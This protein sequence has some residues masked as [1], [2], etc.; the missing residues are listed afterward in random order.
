MIKKLL[1]LFILLSQIAVAQSPQSFK[2]QSV[3]R[4]A[5]GVLAANRIISIRTSILAGSATGSSVYTETQTLSTNDYGVVSLNIGA[6]TVVSG[7]FSTINWGATNYF[8]KTELDINGGST[9]IFMGTSQILSVP[10]ALY[11]EKAGNAMADHDTSSTNELQTLSVAGH[12]LSISN[13]NTVLLPP[14]ADSSATNELQNLSVSGHSIAISSGN[15]VLLPKDTLTVNGYTLGVSNGNT[16]NLPAP[17]NL[18]VNGHTIGITSGNSVLI[19]R[20]TLAV[21]GYSLGITNGNTV[22]LPPPQNLSIVGDSLHITNGNTIYL[23]GA[24]D[25]DSDPTNELQNLTLHNDTLKISR[26][27]ST[28]VFP[29]DNDRDSTN[30]LQNLSINQGTIHISKG[31]SISLPDSSATNELQN[32]SINQGT[33]SISQGNSIHLPDSSATNELQNLIVTNDTLISI[34]QGN[35]AYINTSRSLKFPEGID[36]TPITLKDIAGSPIYY[37]VPNGK[38]LYLTNQWSN[39]TNY[40]YG[41]PVFPSGTILSLTNTQLLVG[42]LINQNSNVQI[43]STQVTATSTY[44]VP[45]GKYF[46][47]KSFVNTGNTADFRATLPSGA[48][49]VGAS[50][51]TAEVLIFPS[52]TIFSSPTSGYIIKISGYLK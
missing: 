26:T 38:N 1:S 29:R 49:Y 9:Y 24:V 19:P 40:I 27:N 37:T 39:G 10:Y 15:N 33:L 43:I 46:Y 45:A 50:N 36:G 13:G 25:L 3:V 41:N 44:T 30:E 8:V 6:G 5:S 32:L 21:N 12:H 16:V 4:D 47:L 28:V 31:N 51:E 2:Y 48:I 52:G 18:T 20:D 35:S 42:I 23:S 14:D 17:Q 34:S 22:N 11:A 7:N